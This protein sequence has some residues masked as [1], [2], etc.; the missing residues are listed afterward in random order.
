MNAKEALK[1]VG[2]SIFVYAI[3]AA[4][5]SGNPPGG[6]ADGGTTVRDGSGGDSPGILDA[7]LDPVS[8]AHAGMPIVATEN[9]NKQFMSQ[10][11]AE[12]LFTGYTA[13]QLALTVA[14]VHFTS[15]ANPLGSY[16][17]TQ[18]AAAVKDGAVAVICGP[19]SNPVFDT[20]T[21]VLPQ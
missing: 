20:V 18:Q 2:G 7:L 12:H 5:G 11:Y 8:E 10:A 9:C 16:P 17:Y 3:M 14:L 4:C 1:L 19:A 6:T 21:F 15:G 13:Q